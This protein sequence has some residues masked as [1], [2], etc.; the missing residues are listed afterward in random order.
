VKSDHAP[1]QWLSS[2]KD[3]NSRRMRWTLLLQ[4]YEFSI[5]HI[6]G[7]DNRIADP[8]SRYPVEPKLLFCLGKGEMCGESETLP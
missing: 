5:K 3:T 6:K 8:L 4:E 7:K 1:L 2:N